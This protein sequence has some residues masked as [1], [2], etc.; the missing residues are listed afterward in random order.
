MT[1]C[2]R[3]GAIALVIVLLAGG[4]GAWPGGAQIDAEPPL[5]VAALGQHPRIL[6]TS[7]YIE[8][9]L[10]P[11][12][13]ANTPTWVALAA[14]LDSG[15]PEADAE[16]TPGA[17][18]RSL[19]AGWLVT[20]EFR[21]AERAQKLMVDL[22]NRVEMHPVM[23]GA[24]GF[25]GEFMEQ[26]A[27]L[28]V[29]YD[30]LYSALTGQDR[31]ALR[32]VLWRASVRL[33]DP[34]ADTDN[35]VWLDGALLAFGNYEPRWLWALTATGL[36]LSGEHPD[37]SS[38]LSFCRKTLVGSVIPALDL[39]TGGAWAEGPVYGF[40]AN[41]PRV[42]TALAW[43]TAAGENYFDDTRWWYDRL[44]Y[45]LFLY[46]P[47]PARTYNQ[48]WGE[49]IHDYPSIIGDSE[50]YHGAAAYGRAQDLL[51][52]AVFAGSAHANW[53]DWFLRQPPDSAPDWMAVEEFL[54]RDP[55]WAGFPPPDLTWTAPYAGHV[56]MR[57]NWVNADGQLDPG[58]TYVSFV[59]G[60]RLAYHQ[61]YDQGSFTLFHNGADLVVRSGVYS[62]DGTS[63]HDANYY[64]RTI[65]GNTILVCD[66]AENF[67]G[68]RP[69]GE[70][71]VWLND[72]GQR[73]MRPASRTAINVEYLLENWRAYDTGS[74][75]R[76]G[77]IDGITYLRADITGAYNSTV[78][79]TPENRAKVSLV[80]RELV[81]LRPGT[82]IVSDRVNTTYPSYTPMTLFHFQAAPQPDG[83]F[84]RV[85]VDG[86]ALYLQNMLPDSRVTLVEGYEV[87]GQLID[88][89][90]GE[91]VSNTFEDQPYG[92]YR[93]EIT[94]ANPDM[95]YWFLTTLIA[96]NAEA[97]RPA[98]NLLVLGEGVRG[99]VRGDVQVMFDLNP[100]DG[101]DVTAAVFPL[102]S[103]V[104]Q[105]LLTGLRPNAVYR[106]EAEGSFV[107][108][109]QADAAG[110]L[111]LNDVPPGE[112]SLGLDEAESE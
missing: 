59:A 111:L 55:E 105:M 37:A 23:T 2:K 90:W 18:V 98:E 56:F 13:E 72:C 8:E 70:R 6:L 26:V 50:R 78:Y 87:A 66:L 94:P 61:F 60:D 57:S 64:V 101:A 83:L 54:W 89:S 29:G 3:L 99:V 14:Y 82:V 16:W 86:S 112:I 108:T 104:R 53:M 44:A 11:R 21:Y 71:D 75:V 85:Q 12:R 69:N 76:Q 58:A 30:W 79:A 36:A 88:E 65:A 51:L 33:R 102:S 24:G 92:I 20:G 110:L 10:R 63:D 1:L 52:R 46:Y 100:G 84:F 17:A 109:V 106:L 34:A 68:I 32:D 95:A 96:Q 41:W 62:G 74:I 39:Q 9:T 43:W 77:E 31:A 73:T 81:Y 28:A 5:P 19:A 47:T 93:L 42:Q 67:D 27:A 107:Q 40:I 7:A 49:P 15:A 103:G 35:I 97:D 22:V 45:D 48:D 38:L 91:P 80:Q 25:D 4:I